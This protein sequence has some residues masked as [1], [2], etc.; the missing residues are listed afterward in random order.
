[1]DI[2]S[3]PRTATVRII[4]D[5]RDLMSIPDDLQVFLICR[6]EDSLPLLTSEEYPIYI[7]IQSPDLR[8]YPIER[9][10]SFWENWEYA[11][12]TIH[13]HYG[14]PQF[15]SPWARKDSRESQQ[16]S[17]PFQTLPGIHYVNVPYPGK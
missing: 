14:K 3:T 8:L 15:N 16:N 4:I 2:P 7:V 12:N 1:M 13:F 6:P 5:Y 17:S 11:S 9:I 10:P